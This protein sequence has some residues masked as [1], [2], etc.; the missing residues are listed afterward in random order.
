VT[1]MPA[2][3]TQSFATITTALAPTA[4]PAHLPSFVVDQPL[5]AAE[6]AH[7]VAEDPDVIDLDS[8]R[9]V[10]RPEPQVGHWSCPSCDLEAGPF[11]ADEAVLLAA[12]HDQVMRHPGNTASL[13][14][15]AG[16]EMSVA[17]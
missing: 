6:A 12:V 3:R 4:D 2:D 1:A 10:R 5:D 11:T 14:L 9:R 7:R 8:V 17:R 15:L 16:P 13:R